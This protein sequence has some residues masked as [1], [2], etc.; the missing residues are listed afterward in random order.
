MNVRMNALTSAGLLCLAAS[1]AQAAPPAYTIVDLGVLAHAKSSQAHGISPNGRRIVGR[2]LGSSGFPAVEWTNSSGLLALHKLLDRPYAQAYG[3]NDAGVV[4]GLS[5]QTAFGSD[6]LPVMWVNGAA[7]K[8][9]VP[10]GQQTGQAMAINASGEIVGSLNSDVFQRAVAWIGGVA[11]PLSATTEDGSYMIE[12]TGINDDGLICGQGVDPNNAALNVGLVYDS[13]TGMVSDIGALP[14]ANGALPFGISNGGYVV[15]SSMLYQ[16]S[17]MPFVW[18]SA[19][20]MVG[21]PLPPQTSEGIAYGVNSQGWTVGVAGGVY[22]VPF[23]YEG[24]TTYTIASL[25]SAPGWNFSTTTSASAE[26]ISEDGTITGTGVYM[27]QTHGY[28]LMPVPS[29]AAPR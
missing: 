23:L 14:G 16:G 27:G 1:A 15:G 17:G 28:A 2:A 26:S 18:S 11:T 3:V 5:A 29:G 7:I 25:V 19:T 22:A 4:V 8:L 13:G 6:P 10:H 21:I 9:Q 20:G 12:A 24:G